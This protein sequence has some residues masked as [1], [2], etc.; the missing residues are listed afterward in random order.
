MFKVS[1]ATFYRYIN[2]G[3]PAANGMAAPVGEE[4]SNR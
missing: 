3:A 4:V 1:R 2:D